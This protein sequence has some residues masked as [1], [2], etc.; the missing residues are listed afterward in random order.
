MHYLIQIE[1]RDEKTH[2]MCAFEQYFE[3]TPAWLKYARFVH[4]GVW[5]VWPEGVDRFP[6]VASMSVGVTGPSL[7]LK[8]V[9]RSAIRDVGN[10]R[11]CLVGTVVTKLARPLKTGA[12]RDVGND[13]LRFCLVVILVTE[14]WLAHP[15][16]T[17][18]FPFTG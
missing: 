1:W 16:K 4:P 9:P 3:A 13:N 14:G 12:F 2:R 18:A 7:T 17:G 8:D 6:E 10:L 5:Q 11:F 15:L